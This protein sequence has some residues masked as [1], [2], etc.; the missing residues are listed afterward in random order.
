MA[1]LAPGTLVQV[2]NVV[3]AIGA[4]T[5]NVVSTSAI[6][7][8]GSRV[9]LNAIAAL[10]GPDV[11]ITWRAPFVKTATPISTTAGLTVR[12][13]RTRYFVRNDAETPAAPSWRL[14]AISASNP[15]AGTALVTVPAAAALIHRCFGYMVAQEDEAV[16]QLFE[17]RDG[18]TV[19]TAL[20]A[21]PF[22]G[23]FVSPVPILVGTVNTAMTINN[24]NAPGAGIELAAALL[25]E[26]A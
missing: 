24:R 22:G 19:V 20:G 21:P 13:I 11:G 16:N 12:P 3:D 6:L 15:A 8:D 18:A 25:V 9:G 2:E 5:T 4:V 14:G 1:S 23:A 26:T 10:F 17:L 7:G